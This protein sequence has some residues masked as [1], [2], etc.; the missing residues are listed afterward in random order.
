MMVPKVK[1]FG[2]IMDMIIFGTKIISPSMEVARVCEV[3]QLYVK[4]KK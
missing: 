3:L 1:G 4:N 2:G